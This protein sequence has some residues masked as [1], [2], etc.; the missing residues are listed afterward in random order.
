[1]IAAL[2]A[3][4]AQ[5]S[6]ATSTTR[7]SAPTSERPRARAGLSHPFIQHKAK[8]EE[9]PHP[10]RERPF[11]FTCDLQP[12][13]DGALDLHRGARLGVRD[14]AARQRLAVYHQL[15]LPTLARVLH[16]DH[17]GCPADPAR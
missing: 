4:R 7:A 3:A 13:S 11:V 10:H 5:A 2:A 8:K 14:A 16:R 6:R 1:M 17:V 9:G 12:S 15:A